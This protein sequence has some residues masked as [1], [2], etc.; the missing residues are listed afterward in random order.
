MIH[1]FIKHKRQKYSKQRWLVYRDVS[2]SQSVSFVY[3]CYYTILTKIAWPS[4]LALDILMQNS[5]FH[6]QT[7]VLLQKLIKFGF[8]KMSFGNPGVL[9]C[10]MATPVA[11]FPSCSYVWVQNQKFFVLWSKILK[12]IFEVPKAFEVWG[13]NVLEYIM[14]LNFDIV[15]NSICVNDF[16]VYFCVFWK[17]IA[18]YVEE[19]LCLI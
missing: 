1:N 2:I 10:C 16:K 9:A 3:R 18:C 17:E 15:L 11:S 4:F 19:L 8:D 7:Q 5:R 6:Y 14:R 13:S 12:S